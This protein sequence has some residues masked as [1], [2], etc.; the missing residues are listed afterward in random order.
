[1]LEENRHLL[2]KLAEALLERE[3][4]DSEEIRRVCEG[5]KL[6]P[7]ADKENSEEKKEA[8]KVKGRPVIVPQ[9]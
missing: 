2:E 5:L 4:L 3:T 6:E 9:N 8:A 1:M 7:L